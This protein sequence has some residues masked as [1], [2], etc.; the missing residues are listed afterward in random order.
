MRAIG[1]FDAEISTGAGV[2]FC[3]S[4]AKAGG[5]IVV[6]PAVHVTH[7]DFTGYELGDLPYHLRQWD[8]LR[9]QIALQRLVDKYGVARDSRIV[10]SK[11]SFVAWRRAA[12]GVLARS[13]NPPP[14]LASLEGH[15]YAQ[16]WP[17]LAMQLHRL[18]FG[19]R[20]IGSV[21]RCHEFVHRNFAGVAT[22]SGKPLLARAVGAASILAA[23]GAMPM[24]IRAAMI[25]DVYRIGSLAMSIKRV[26]P[27]TRRKRIIGVAGVEAEGISFMAREIDWSRAPTVA[28]TYDRYT[29]A[30]AQAL[31]LRVAFDIDAQLD[32]G[33]CLSR[34]TLPD[35]DKIGAHVRTILPRL[36]FP[37][38]ADAW[39]RAIALTEAARAEI[40]DYSGGHRRRPYVAFERKPG[41]LKDAPKLISA[42]EGLRG[43]LFGRAMAAILPGHGGAVE[44]VRRRRKRLHPPPR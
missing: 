41:K 12:V 28:P 15:P 42:R 31:L 19:P 18:G 32:R 22:P 6:Q 13:I 11:S 40:P 2:D 21:R 29:L 4:V 1:R 39:S 5:R 7:P 24:L 43:G 33:L 3:L 44:V 9:A 35:V 38:L 25:G 17:Q 26:P 37:A 14:E 34:E 8:P 20:E 36:G 27:D 30:M 16:T 10:I 23:H